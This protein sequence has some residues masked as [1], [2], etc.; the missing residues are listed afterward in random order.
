MQRSFEKCQEFFKTLKFNFS[1]VYLSQ[2]RCE[3]LDSTKDSNYRLHG[4]ESFHPYSSS[5]DLTPTNSRV[6]IG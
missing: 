4:Y 6:L 5:Y 3:S 1:A 2:T